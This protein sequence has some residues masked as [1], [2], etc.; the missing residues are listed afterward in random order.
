MLDTVDMKRSGFSTLLAT[1]FGSK[2]ETGKKKKSSRRSGEDEPPTSWLESPIL[3]VAGLFGVII[4]T[5][6]MFWP[7]SDAEKFRRAKEIIDRPEAPIDEM[8]TADEVFLA[9]ILA[10][11]SASPL[12]GDIA[13]LREK[14]E[15]TRTRGRTNLASKTGILD[16][17]ATE[18]ERQ[19]VAALRLELQ[20]DKAN[21]QSRYESVARMFS[22]DPASKPIVTLAMEKLSQG[23]K[24][25][26]DE[27]RVQ[28][29]ASR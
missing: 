13:T 19:Y 8:V 12:A 23:D 20:G 22:K 24:Y 7:L 15:V 9:P 29:N 16:A 11:D 18:A 25:D 14:I 21:A 17:K 6:Y 28:A 4:F 5:S 10:A 26:S 1:V 3:L 2:E 27:K